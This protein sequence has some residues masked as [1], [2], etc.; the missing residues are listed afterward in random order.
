MGGYWLAIGWRD[1]DNTTILIL[2]PNRITWACSNCGCI[3]FHERGELF[4]LSGVL[5]C[6]SSYFGYILFAEGETENEARQRD[7]QDRRGLVRT[8]GG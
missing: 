4:K 3:G 7:G 1:R 8:A 6:A 2:P 5:N